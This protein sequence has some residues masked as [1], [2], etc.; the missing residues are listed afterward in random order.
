MLKT[1]D[2]ILLIKMIDKTIYELNKS[3]RN[4]NAYYLHYMFASFGGHFA[5][6]GCFQRFTVHCPCDIR[7]RFSQDRDVVFDCFA[8]FQA[9]IFYATAGETWWL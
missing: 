9:E 8:D 3:N 7:Q 1:T 4:F 2:E 5:S 6:S